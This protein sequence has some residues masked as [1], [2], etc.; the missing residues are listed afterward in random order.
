[1]PDEADIRDSPLETEVKAA[2]DEVGE[3]ES[4][5]E[6]GDED[7]PYRYSVSKLP[8]WLQRQVRVVIA[9]RVLLNRTG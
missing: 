4:E 2:W 7:V 5:E 9:E 6:R 1:M 3:V 8:A